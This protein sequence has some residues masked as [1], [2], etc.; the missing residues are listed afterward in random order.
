MNK[1]WIRIEGSGERHLT[2]D[3]VQVGM[4]WRGIDGKW[5]AAHHPVG[6]SCIGFYDDIKDA[7]SQVERLAEKGQVKP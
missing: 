2:V 5:A 7:M 4:V 6:L 3:G 1:I